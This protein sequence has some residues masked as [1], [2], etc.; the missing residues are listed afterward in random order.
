MRIAQII[1]RSDIIGGASTHLLTLCEH[2]AD[3]GHD[4]TVYCGGNGIF[5]EEL[6]KRELKYH[7]LSHLV[8]PIRPFEDLRAVFEVQREI[9]KL[10][11]DIVALHSA[12]AG[13]VGRIACWWAQIPCVVTAHG[14]AFTEG[15]STLRRYF[16]ASIERFVAPLAE[17]I[18]TVSDFDQELAA[19][20]S[21]AS[22]KK[23]VTVYNG[24]QDVDQE[25]RLASEVGETP[26]IIMVAR[27]EPQKD[28]PTLLRALEKLRGASWGALFVGDGPRLEQCVDLARDLGIEDRVQFLGYRSDVP[29]L[30][31]QSDL[32]VL[33]T[34]YEGFP[35]A[36]VEAMR[37]GLPIVASDVGGVSEQVRSEE[38]GFLV[39]PEDVSALKRALEDL[40]QNEEKRQEMGE[41][42]RK[43]FREQFRVEKMVDRTLNVYKEAV[44]QGKQ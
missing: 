6:E 39:P 41:T 31:A 34:H 2:L 26:R 22:R 33:S 5:T 44:R 30:L 32:F 37:A 38:N 21:V 4:V 9:E 36:T 40:L 23:M 17:R 25:K 7:S 8:R 10:N 13:V 15:K 19:D 18:I 16:L 29:N 27:F 42:G 43:I 12:K 35:I 1:T 11:P 24:V 20:W 3:R 14:W 28:Q